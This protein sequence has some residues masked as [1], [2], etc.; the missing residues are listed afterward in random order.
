MG[1]SFRLI[2][3]YAGYDGESPVLQPLYDLGVKRGVR[4]EDDIEM[5]EN[6]SASLFV[7]WNTTYRLPWQTADYYREQAATLTHNEFL[8]VHRNQWV[9]S[10]DTFVPS[11]WWRNC[12][13]DI[14]P[15]EPYEQWLLALDAAVSGDSFGVLG[16]SRREDK[17]LVRYARRWLPV[18]GT[19]LDFGE[20]EAE[21]RRLVAHHPVLMVTYDPYQL[22]DM[23]TRLQVEL[24][25]W[26]EPFQQGAD[27]AIADKQ[28][29]DFIRDRRIVHDGS[30]DLTEHLVNA[31]AKTEGERL[32]LVK[33]TEAGKIDLAVCLSM[34]T[35][36]AMELNL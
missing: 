24:G 4:I 8:R 9:T 5:Y 14:P 20:P 16:L 21:L 19:K 35:A 2:E 30:P 17:V 7:Y 13:G 32:R 34:A 31:N 10:T 18:Q 6:T 15:L 33:R 26:F 23:A 25:I 22:H 11:E 27:R 28:L 1:T 12:Q 29:Y 36:K 3:S